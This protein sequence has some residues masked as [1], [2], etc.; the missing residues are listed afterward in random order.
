MI[1]IHCIIWFYKY[2]LNLTDKMTLLH[3]Y[4]LAS[5]VNTVRRQYSSHQATLYLYQMLIDTKCSFEEV[6]NLVRF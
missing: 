6:T 4:L 1:M 3:T 5:S 2:Q